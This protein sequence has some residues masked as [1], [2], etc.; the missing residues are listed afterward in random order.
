MWQRWWSVTKRGGWTENKAIFYFLIYLCVY[1]K[2]FINFAEYPKR[3]PLWGLQITEKE[4]K[5][6]GLE[7]LLEPVEGWGNFV[8]FWA[9]TLLYLC[10]TCQK[11][12]SFT[13]WKLQKTQKN[14]LDKV[15]T[16]KSLYYSKNMSEHITEIWSLGGWKLSFQ[17]PKWC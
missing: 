2:C 5:S 16:K 10:T 15:S 13:C 12:A 11:P 1:Y 17:P 8:P 7:P 3:T 4:G 6:W 9:A 14:L